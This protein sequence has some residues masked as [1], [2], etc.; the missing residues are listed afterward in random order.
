MKIIINLFFLL[1]VFMLQGCFEVLEEVNMNPDGS[2]A[3]SLTIN[4]SQSKS[5][6]DNVMTKDTINGLKIPR[7]KDIEATISDV[8]GKLKATKGISNV[9]VTRDFTNY[10]LVIKCDFSNVSALNA[11]VNNIWLL[12]DKK[13][14]MNSVYYSSSGKTFRR[15]FDFN[16]IKDVKNKLG[17][18][19]REILG[20][21]IYTMIYRFP[22]EIESKTNPDANI[23]KSRKALILRHSVL[24]IVTGRKSV[25][26]EIKLK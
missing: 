24:D 9:T 10:I 14:N 4:G 19:E 18:Q 25:Q 26:N 8:T 12:Y 13:A 21:A 7:R 17:S 20:K 22:S 11:A 1:S 3:F 16:V 2:G 23:S 6:L 15:S 5:Q